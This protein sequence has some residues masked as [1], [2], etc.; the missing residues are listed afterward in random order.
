MIPEQALSAH[1]AIAGEAGERRFTWD[2]V[3]D[4]KRIDSYFDPFG[5]LTIAQ[6]ARLEAAR[7]YYLLG[8]DPEA[9]AIRSALRA[10]LSTSRSDARRVGKEC[11]STCRSRWSPYH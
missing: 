1:L 4:R 11:V 5:N 3:K 10:E 8:R 6:R 2:G 9:E 7:I